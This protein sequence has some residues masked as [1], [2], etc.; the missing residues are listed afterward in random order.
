MKDWNGRRVVILGA[1]RQGLA[2]ARYLSRHGARVTLNDRRSQ[3]ELDAARAAL[4]DIQGRTAYPV[5]W[6]CGGHPPEVLE[7][8]ELVCLSG[9]VPTTLPLV[10]EAQARRIPLSNDS[11]IFLELAPCR[12]IGIT[13]SA[14][15][16]TTTTLVGR[17]AQAAV[18]ADQ[19]KLRRVWVGGNIGSPL[20]SVVDEMSPQ[21]LVVMELSSFQL[22]I[23]TKSPQIAA[24]LNITPN[25]LDRH[26]SM[27]AYTAAKARIIQHQTPDDIAVL[28]RD[29]RGAWSLAEK[30]QG[31]L[32]TFGL[33]QPRANQIPGTFMRQGELY[34]EQGGETAWLMSRTMIGLRGE[35]NLLNV[36]AACAISL[37]ADLPLE[38][39]RQGVRGF[40]GVAHRLEFVRTWGG[41]DW[42]N[43]SIATAPERTIAAIRSFDEPLVL[44]VGGRDKDLPWDELAALAG[45]RVRR[46][47]VFG[48]A[49]EKIIQAMEA[50]QTGRLPPITRCAGLKQ[51]VQVAAQVVLPGDVVLL[52]PGGTS[53]DEF[54][55]FEERGECFKQLVMQL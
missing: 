40:S 15:K 32:M 48:E 26:G 6:V 29:D 12:V 5:K 42:Y 4:A 49:A 3:D 55:D 7:G 51:A 9:G 11:Q 50:G 37:A 10:V 2:L 27:Q 43:D 23:M 22:E 17:M 8:A 24:V 36:L 1:A 53:F 21:D 34:F 45:E 47:I 33:E 30:V 20:I 28:G 52:S 38:A 39:I 41:A 46:L 16:T 18:T 13:G 25:H 19:T 54:R 14:G 31:R 44:L 35:H